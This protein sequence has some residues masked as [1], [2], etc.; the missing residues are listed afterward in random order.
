M[1]NNIYVQPALGARVGDKVVVRFEEW[2]SRHVNPEGEIIEVLGPA[3]APGIDMLSI[4]R[5]FQLPLAFPEAVERD[6][7]RFSDSVDP[8]EIARREDCRQQFIVTID[9]DDAKDF[10]DAIHVERLP[11]GGWRLAVHI[12]DV[13]HYVRPGH[14]LDREARKRGNSTYLA[15]RV[16]PMLP[17]HL[18]NGICSLKPNVERLTFAAFIDFDEQGKIR[19]ARFARCV[20]KSAARMTYRQALAV[21]QDKPAPPT[22]NYERGGKVHLDAK[23]IPLV[24]TPELPRARQARTRELRLAPPQESLRR[25]L[26][27][28]RFPRGQSLA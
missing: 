4:I 13:S 9:P 17:E 19:K 7:Q 24:V 16:I 5:K 2:E 18:S 23:P 15:D 3:Q 25:R 21:L 27:R 14:A 11:R 6:A 10:D 20:I 26:A 8:A 12:A 22:P 28:S 1:Q